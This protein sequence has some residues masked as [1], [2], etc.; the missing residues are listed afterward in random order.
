MKSKRLREIQQ[1][2]LLRGVNTKAVIFV[3]EPLSRIK[4]AVRS[5]LDK[6]NYLEGI[7]LN[8]TDFHKALRQ[9]YKSEHCII[10]TRYER[11]ISEAKNV[12]SAEN[13]YLGFYENMFEHHEVR[14]LSDFLQIDTKTEFANVRVNKTRSSV[15][16]TDS[17]AAI[18]EFYKDTYKYFSKNYRIT[19]NLWS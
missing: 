12:F 19:R 17:D 9:Y 11:I 15:Y 7:S 3:R 16:D 4:S 5:N 6:N 2:F 13:L 8:E 14:R 10:R 1:N 18:R